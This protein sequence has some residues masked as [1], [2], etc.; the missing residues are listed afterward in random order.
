M[1]ANPIRYLLSRP[2]LSGRTARWLLQLSEFY[3]E[4]FTPFFAI[5]DADK[6]ATFCRSTGPSKDPIE[7]SEEIPGDLE[8]I[9]TLEDGQ[10][11]LYFDESSTAGVGIVFE[12]IKRRVHIFI[13]FIFVSML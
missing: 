9:A 8:Q 4:C 2:A 13:V 11:T 3:I 5:K 6:G 7:L 1:G 12:I 10:W